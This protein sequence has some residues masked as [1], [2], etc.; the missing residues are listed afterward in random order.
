MVTSTINLI[1][2]QE[3]MT[4]GSKKI[5]YITEIEGLSRDGLHEIKL[6]DLFR[7][8]IEGVSPDGKVLGKL[9]SVIKHY[10]GFFNKLEKL[11][12]SV[13]EALVKKD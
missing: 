7:F 4:D 12:F 11:G 3:R 2:H 13:A 8:Q 5:T 6:H 10:P 1:V 9:K